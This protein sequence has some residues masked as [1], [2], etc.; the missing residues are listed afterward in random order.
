MEITFIERLNKVPDYRKGNAIRHKLVDIRVIALL[1]FICNGNGY[2]AMRIFG[3]NHEDELK[4]IL[5][6]PNGIPSQDTFEH[7]FSKLVPTS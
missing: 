3:K 2:A 1:T 7:V 6:L 4:K 5:E